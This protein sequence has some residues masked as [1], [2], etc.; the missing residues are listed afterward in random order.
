MTEREYERIIRVQQRTIEQLI[1][2]LEDIADYERRNP[3]S[4]PNCIVGS[5]GLLNEVNQAL[6]YL[7]E[8]T[9]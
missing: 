6:S 2:H 8:V 7:P 1:D 4:A 3:M 5:R 9:R